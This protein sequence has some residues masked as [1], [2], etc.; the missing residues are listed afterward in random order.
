MPKGPFA[1]SEFV[2]TEWSTAI[3]KANFGNALLHFL[4][5]RC[6]R[7][8][9]TKKFYTR[10][11]M[12]FGNI[13]HYN[14][15]GFYDTWFTRERH[16]LAF[17]QKLLRWPCHGDPKF[18]FSDVEYAVQRVMRQRNDLARFELGAIEE[19]RSAEMKDLERL[20]AKYRKP[21]QVLSPADEPKIVPAATSEPAAISTSAVQ[22]SLF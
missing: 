1:P 5:A 12:T 2:P 9:F 11:S 16:Q 7:E 6:P 4:G 22:I 19:L 20:E 13:A 15:E 18:T 8:L 21:Q 14:I 3:E 10:L 17:V